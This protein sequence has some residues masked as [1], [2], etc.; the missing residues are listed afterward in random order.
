MSIIDILNKSHKK[1]QKVNNY[2]K[3]YDCINEN[4]YKLYLEINSICELKILNA[5]FGIS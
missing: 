1:L 3:F 5:K 2:W 4:L